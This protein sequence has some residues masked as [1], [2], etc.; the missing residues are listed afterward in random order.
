DVV[1]TEGSNYDNG[2]TGGSATVGGENVKVTYEGNV[3][4]NKVGTYPV[5]I[6]ATNSEGVTTSK[7][8]TVKVVAKPE[9]VKPQ[10]PVPIVNGHDVV[11]T[12][13]SNYDNG[14]TGG[15]ATV[16]GENVK[17]EH[18]DNVNI[19]KNNAENSNDNSRAVVNSI[20]TNTNTIKNK[21]VNVI[22]QLPNT[23]ISGAIESSAGIEGLAGL[24][25]LSLATV[26]GAFKIKRKHKKNKKNKKND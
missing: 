23:G 13:G 9:P 12:E 16:G 24:M 20:V 21:S 4:T 7:T 3:N 22:K 2:M 1:I 15:S 5:T 14:M 8:V 26:V 19:Q 10:V 18:I 25:S 11:I 6:I 17:V